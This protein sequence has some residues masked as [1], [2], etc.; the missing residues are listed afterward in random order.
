MSDLNFSLWRRT[1]AWLLIAL[2]GA[3]AYPA[4]AAEPP[5]NWALAAVEAGLARAR[6]AAVLQGAAPAL[7]TVAVIDSGVDAAHPALA[8]RL[9]PGLNA[10]GGAPGDTGDDSGDAHGTHVAGV[11]AAATEGY[12]V[13]ILPVKVLEADSS[14][15]IAALAAGI[16]AAADWRGPGGERVR[17]INLSLGERL[18]AVPS[19]LSEA[20][21]YALLREILLVAAGGNDGRP[22]AGYYPAA[23]PGVL[24]VGATA[25]DHTRAP[26]SGDGALLLAPGVD[27]PG[28]VSGAPRTGSSFAAPFVSA[29][30]ALI[31]SV[32]PGA[33][34]LEVL[35]AVLGAHRLWPCPAVRGCPVFSMDRAL[36]AL[37][38]VRAPA[39]ERRFSLR[40]LGGG[41]LELVWTPRRSPEMTGLAM[42]PTVRFLATTA[43]G[44]APQPI[45]MALHLLMPVWA[46]AP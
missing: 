42:V 9:W 34:R 20:V 32:H 40:F 7:V 13:K 35:E 30:A 36:G 24:S 17:V 22:V 3:T 33:R 4:A 43:G 25:R 14:G 8:R 41:L 10:V 23:L 45:Y 29:G 2:L 26:R 44:L 11:I 15:S 19:A 38:E 18:D 12:P 6:G 37:G 21:R 39:P 46:P 28:A 5:E 1:A 27:V 16:R 31:W